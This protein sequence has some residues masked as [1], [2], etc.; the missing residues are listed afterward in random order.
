[1]RL[2]IASD[3]ILIF[4]FFLSAIL[5][6]SLFL[7]IPGVFA[8]GKLRYIDALFTATSAI[9]VTGLITVDTPD[10]SMLGQSIIMVLIQAGGLGIITFSTIFLASSR[11]RISIVGRGVVGEYSVSEVEYKPKVIIKAIVKYTLIF[12]A[13]GFVV[14]LVAFG[15]KGIRVFDALFHAVSAFCN[16]GFSTFRNSLEAYVTNPLVNLNTIFLIVSGGLG[17][18]VIKD[19][20]KLITGQRRHLS[21][22]SN[23]VL[24][25]SF[26]LLAAG[27]IAFFIL[28]GSQSMAGLNFLEK[29]IASLFQA[30]TPRTA[31]FNTIAQSNLSQGSQLLTVLLMFIGASP[32]STGGGIKTTT[33][34]I[35]LITAFRYRDSNDL[36]SYGKRKIQPRLIFKAVGVVVKAIL[37]VLVASVLI[38]IIEAGSG[39]SLA[40][41]IFEIVSAFGTVGLS[42]GIT[43]GLKDASKIILILTMFIGRVGL[44]ALALPK[45][46]RDVDGYADLPSAEVLI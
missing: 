18:L 40:D 2:R 25:T 19:I 13:V 29:L 24:R 21:Y 5:F 23:I 44:F 26:S 22:H 3:K 45:T 7:S 32:A 15:G 33:F 39:L 36:I 8:A 16:A 38:I 37:I 30:T 43:A 17:F 1:M 35:L 10:F 14:Y 46:K 42:K 9:C 27:T 31:G 34:Y 41:A 28:E 4:S 20:R 12:E 6:G 11:R